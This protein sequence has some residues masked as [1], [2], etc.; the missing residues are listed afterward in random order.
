MRSSSVSSLEG[1]DMTTNPWDPRPWAENGDELEY[2]IF[3][4]VGRFLS[5]WENQIEDNIALI[6]AL[7]CTGGD[8]TAGMNVASRAFGAITTARARADVLERAVEVLMLQLADRAKDKPEPANQLADLRTDFDD[9]IKRYRGF[10]SRRNEI[11]HGTVHFYPML[12]QML[13]KEIMGPKYRDGFVLGPPS[14]NVKKVSVFGRPTYLLN[15]KQIED[16]GNHVM[17]FGQ[18]LPHWFNRLVGLVGD[19]AE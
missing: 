6:F 7:V 12:N 5:D 14:Y 17:R 8:M 9:L 1:F 11:A 4:A 10:G 16:I 15:S 2:T 3:H 18:V 19:L 13:G